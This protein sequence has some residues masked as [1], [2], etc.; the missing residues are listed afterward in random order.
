MAITNWFFYYQMQSGRCSWEQ[1]PAA[2]KQEIVTSKHPQYTTALE[3]DSVLDETMDEAQRAAVKYRG[4]LYFDWDGASD[5]EMGETINIVTTFLDRLEQEFEIDPACLRIYATGGRGFHLEI[6]WEVFS[7]DDG[8]KGLAYLHAVY[9]EMAYTLGTQYMD[10][11][12][13]SGG[14]GRMWRTPNVRRDNG[15]FKVPV[16]ADELRLMSP[17]SYKAMTSGPRPE[18]LQAKPRLSAK[19]AVLYAQ[20]VQKIQNATRAKKTA[21]KDKDILKR[22]GGVP[23]SVQR[24]YA[25]DGINHQCGLNEIVMQLAITASALGTDNA[26]DFIKQCEGF[27]K[28]RAKRPGDKHKNE[29][30]I[31]AELRRIF[32]Y[33]VGNLRYEYSIE[34]LRKIMEPEFRRGS[35]DLDGL[36]PPADATP[37]EVQSH[38]L[39]SLSTGIQLRADCFVKSATDQAQL[40]TNWAPDLGNAQNLVD[41]DDPTDVELLTAYRVDGQIK[42]TLAIN[43]DLFS[44]PQ[45]FVRTLN[46]KGAVATG[47]TGMKDTQGMLAAILSG[48][49][50]KGVPTV[51]KVP[52]EGMLVQKRADGGG[53]DIMWLSPKGDILPNRPPERDY[54]VV[55]FTGAQGVTLSDVATADD[56]IGSEAERQVFEAMLNFNGSDF[57]VAAMLGWFAGTFLRPVWI[58]KNIKQYPLLQVMGQAG[59]GKTTSVGNLS[60]LYYNE[61]APVVKTAGKDTA[62]ALQ[63]YICGSTTVPLFLDEFKPSSIGDRRKVG[64]INGIFHDVYVAGQVVSKGGGGATGRGT[65]RTLSNQYMV[66]P[67]LFIGER[68]HSQT[69]VQERCIVVPFSKSKLAGWE[70]Y[71]DLLV[72]NSSII[73]QIGKAVIT[74]VVNSS[75]EQLVALHDDAMAEAREK[76]SNGYNH[77]IVDS[78]GKVLA[79]L[80]F[81]RQVSQKHFDD[82]YVDRFSALEDALMTP[83]NHSNL[84]VESEAKKVFSDLSLL[85]HYDAS[86]TYALRHG[87]D[88]ALA[89]G[90][91]DLH[92]DRCFVKYSQFCKA[93]D[94]AP[95]YEDK[96]QMR[97][98]LL[99]YVALADARPQSELSTSSNTTILRFNLAKLEAEGVDLFREG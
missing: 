21:R 64:E 36:A 62:Y 54:A 91:I 23:P 3:L 52:T 93:I 4:P 10:Q 76:M 87:I 49:K 9:R 69:A 28:E 95:L 84:V 32:D 71:N 57:V 50:S 30:A 86:I 42:G 12:V 5:D 24:M 48:L 29:P 17:E 77:R 92:V 27:V 37:E 83:T 58:A 97:H 74:R 65:W 31:R 75:V 73:S 70:R 68:T 88:Y 41:I 89:D 60:K 98:G 25:G 59:S 11:T 79:G 85:S 15:Q 39:D 35:N 8:S 34:A 47:V 2:L 26:G 55:P 14:R 20:S 6:P 78:V 94:A 81:F 80:R 1:A 66:S 33:V 40:M 67:L 45:E 63:Q 13:Y 72:R 43:S 22:Y 38:L 99:H 16:T 53:F 7:A 56:L 82:R 96:Q 18:P 90:C 46:S 19:M 51:I 61:A 44:A